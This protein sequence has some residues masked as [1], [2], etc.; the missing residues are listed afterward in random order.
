MNTTTVLRVP[1]PRTPNHLHVQAQLVRCL[2]AEADAAP[3]GIR[4]VVLLAAA[5]TGGP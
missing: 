3:P 5:D 1:D 2:I 4:A